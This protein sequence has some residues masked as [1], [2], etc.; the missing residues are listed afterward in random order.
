MEMTENDKKKRYLFGYRDALRKQKAIE[1]EIR[2][3]R[4]KKMLPSLTQDGMPHGSGGSDMS[5]YAAKLDE[6]L[7]DLDEQAQRCIDI[8]REIAGKIEAM[9]D[10]TEKLVLRLRY[11]HGKKWEEIA[12]EMGYEFRYVLKIHGRALKN[13]GVEKT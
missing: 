1:E 2:E 6:L 13:F 8:R 10:E 9:Q 3:L 7:R 5:G 12:V 11:I 4:L